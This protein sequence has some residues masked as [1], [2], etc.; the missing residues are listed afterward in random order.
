M[1]CQQHWFS[2]SIPPFL[3]YLIFP[4]FLP[5][6]PFLLVFYC[7]GYSVSVSGVDLSLPLRP[8]SHGL[9]YHQ[10]ADGYQYQLPSCI[11]PVLQAQTSCHL[12]SSLQTS[13]SYAP[14]MSSHCI[15]TLFSLWQLPQK[16]ELLVSDLSVTSHRQPVCKSYWL[17]PQHVPIV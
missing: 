7:T 13:N 2:R 3:K 12:L 15:I 8:H 6:H 4:I 16:L 17:Y 5:G 11:S 10:E 1:F 14:Q 9:H